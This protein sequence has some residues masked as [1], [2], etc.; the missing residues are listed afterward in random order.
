MGQ[1]PADRYAE[2]YKRLYVKNDLI[3][4]N[5]DTGAIETVTKYETDGANAYER[6]Q[7][8]SNLK[9]CSV[10]DP[11]VMLTNT[12]FRKRENPIASKFY[13]LTREDLAMTAKAFT[14]NKDQMRVINEIIGEPSFI[15][16]SK[17]NKAILWMFRYS[18]T[19]KKEAI[20]KFLMSVAW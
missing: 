6:D 4:N 12:D 17:E 10:Y 9:L 3:K 1:Q 18:L 11:L 19:D 13:D 7:N 5:K 15:A 14:P 20:V 16:V 8:A 2:M